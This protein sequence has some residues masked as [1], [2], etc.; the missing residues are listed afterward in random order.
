MILSGAWLTIFLTPLYAFRLVWYIFYSKPKHENNLVEVPIIMRVPVLI[1]AL[2]A[3]TFLFAPASWQLTSVISKVLPIA[4]N[5]HGSVFILSL[6]LIMTALLVG[7]YM[8]RKR[9]LTTLQP[10]FVPHLFSIV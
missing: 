3:T 10:T 7:F 9:Q 6:A 2:G 1:L 5:A 8:F 4:S